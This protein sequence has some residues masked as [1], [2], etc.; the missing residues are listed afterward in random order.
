MNLSLVPACL[1]SCGRVFTEALYEIFDESAYTRFLARHQ[2]APSREA[3]AEFLLE[4]EA[5]K[6]RRPRCC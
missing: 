3:Y 6:S 5:A 2:L 1:K 4:N